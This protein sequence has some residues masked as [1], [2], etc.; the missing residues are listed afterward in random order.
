MKNV[1]YILFFWPVLL[2]AQQKNLPLE[3]DWAFSADH[4]YLKD[5]DRFEFTSFKPMLEKQGL[6]VVHAAALNSQSHRLYNYGNGP[7]LYRKLK[8]ES[9]IIVHDAGDRFD[10][11]IDPLMNFEF[12]MDLADSSGEKLY[13]NTRGLM[14]RGDIGDKFSFETSFLENQAT[15]PGYIDSYIV[16]TD[17]LFPQTG[18]YD[19]HVV[20]GQGRS[21]KFKTNGYDYA[22]ASGYISYSPWKALN[23]QVGHGKHFVGD[24]YR[25]LLLSDN[26]FNYP[27]ARITTQFA[28][29]RYTN[30]YT[31][32]MN[33]TNGGAQTPAHVERLFQKKVGSFQMLDVELFKHLQIG[34]F[35]GMIW[36]AADTMN[37]QH[38]N[39]NTFDPVI[40]VNA[41]SYGLH[42]KNNVLLGGT[43]KVKLTR[44]MYTYGQFMLDDLKSSH[45]A[46]ANSSKYGYQLG[47]K[48][49]DV[50]TVKNLNLQVEY[51]SVSPYAYASGDPEQSYTHYNQPLAHPLGANFMELCGF[52]NYRTH[53][54]FLQLKG[55][56]AIKGADAVGYNDG[57]NVFLSTTES[58]SS[59]LP[60]TSQLAQGIKQTIV[61]AD[62]RLG[63]LLNPSTNL[64]IYGGVM[65]RAMETTNGA[66]SSSMVVYLGLR[67]SLSNFYFDF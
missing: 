5:S 53:D 12:G 39:F 48:Y 50:F 20:P 52:L 27:Y 57:G 8:K 2:F 30:L 55:I 24:G 67:T 60:G 36:E 43:F 40:G 56:Y 58:A 23:I 47:W 46:M 49:F 59:L 63:Y 35:Q 41:L 11:Y 25:S 61:T 15:Y 14:V 4:Y 19:Y 22:M 54:V 33:L 7:W 9:F 13:K 42:G 31:S 28:H 32:F 62:L 38:L 29:I 1:L 34:L 3:H 10:L 17:D 51:N 66:S 44:H 16:S 65:T 26:S 6:T 37:E 18:N 45:T 64:N 21:K